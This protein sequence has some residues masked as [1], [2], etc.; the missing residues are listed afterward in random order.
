[1]FKRKEKQSLLEARSK[2][3]ERAEKQITEMTQENLVLYKENKELNVENEEQKELIHR[4][5][6]LLNANKYNNEKVFLDK[7]KELVN[8]YQSK[9]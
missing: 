7:L 4:I 9:N 5:I 6:N 3:L 2:S 1:M 8:D